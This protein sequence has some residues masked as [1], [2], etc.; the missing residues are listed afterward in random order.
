MTRASTSTKSKARNRVKVKASPG[1]NG[2]DRTER[3]S[4]SAT[5][6]AGA[7]TV[8]GSPLEA[9]AATFFSH[10]EAYEDVLWGGGGGVSIDWEEL[11]WLLTTKCPGYWKE[12][13]C[14][15]GHRYAMEL[16][17][18]REWCPVCGEEGS[19]AHDRRFSRWLPKAT[20][21]RPMGYFIFTIP[22]DL[23]SKYRTKKALSRLGHQVQELLRSHGYTRG[24]RRWHWFGEKSTRW[25]PHLNILVDGGYLSA[26]TLALIKTAYAG[27]LGCQVVDV[28]YHYRRSPGEMV[29]TL[30]YVTRATFRDYKWDTRMA[31]ELRG[32]RNQLW[33][34]YGKW[35]QEP[36]WSLDDL[37]GKEDLAGLDTRAIE[38]L[39]T[40]I[41]PSPNCGLPIHWGSVQAISILAAQ[42]GKRSLGAGYWELPP[43]PPPELRPRDSILGYLVNMKHCKLERAHQRADAEAGREAEE[44]QSWWY[45]LVNEN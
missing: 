30:K 24:L 40:G 36:V 29:H 14:E 13:H 11:D 35:E 6:V 28:N 27:I 23:R 22:A 3:Q 12:G 39:G 17:C 41:C 10:R 33:W 8:R 21:I 16:H 18:G 19:A 37:Q 5:E 45:S 38:S 25:H 43:V 1:A 44:Y 20:Q 34:G 7:Y 31:I 2:V 32:F 26:E 42:E 9:G 4:E 15:N